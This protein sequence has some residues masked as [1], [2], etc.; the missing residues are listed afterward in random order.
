MLLREQFPELADATIEYVAEGYDH[1]MYQVGEWM[2]RFPKRA[3]VV[4]WGVREV[5]AM[6]VIAAAVGVS[7]PRFEYI[8]RPSEAFPYP[9]AGYRRIPG[10]AA[11][12]AE[13][14][15]L[16]DVARKL[17][18]A[19]TALHSIDPALIPSAPHA[20]DEPSVWSFRWDDRVVEAIPPGVRA[21][22]MAFLR[23]EIP[24]P[25]F[26]GPTRVVHSDL[27]PEHVL[28]DPETGRLTGIIDFADLVIGDP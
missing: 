17:G 4:A 16:E 21:E 5:A 13:C 28:V 8:G 12:E 22:S 2:F 23:G 26:S 24:R 7:V 25:P 11:D 27:L 10:V 9:F 6:P 20:D 14:V 18:R 3:E 15:D 19:L 1:Q